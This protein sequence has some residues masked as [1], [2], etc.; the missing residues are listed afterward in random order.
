MAKRKQYIY[1]TA[2]YDGRYKHWRILNLST[3]SAYASEFESEADALAAIEDMKPR[4]G[5]IVKRVVL[6]DI[7][8]VLQ[9]NERDDNTTPEGPYPLPGEM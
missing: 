4:A 1:E 5:K 2:I 6:K 7:P 9:M 3:G 8:F